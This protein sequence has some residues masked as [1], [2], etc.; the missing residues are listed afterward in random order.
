MPKCECLKNII[1]EQSATTFRTGTGSTTKCD[2]KVSN[3]TAYVNRCE[4]YT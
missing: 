3:G 1:F 2:T 4:E